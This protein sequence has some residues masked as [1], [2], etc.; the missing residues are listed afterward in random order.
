MNSDIY[1]LASRVDQND[2]YSKYPNNVTMYYNPGDI[3]CRK[4]LKMYDSLA[5]NKTFIKFCKVD[6]TQVP[7]GNI[8]QVPVFHLTNSENH[9][10]LQKINPDD[11]E[12]EINFFF[13]PSG[14]LIFND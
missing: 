6:T 12:H 3:N 4:Y 7:V 9:K 5:K 10:I 11:L 2:M 14:R 13:L 8:T 1:T